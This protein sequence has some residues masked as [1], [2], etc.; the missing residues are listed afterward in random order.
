MVVVSPDVGGVV[1]SRALAKYLNGV[2]TTATVR[3]PSSLATF[4]ITGE[5]PVPVPPPIP[6]VMKIILLP[7]M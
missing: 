1:R 6:A 4:A 5:P 2:E 3:I 7:W